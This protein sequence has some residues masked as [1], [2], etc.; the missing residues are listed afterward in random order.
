M[1]V[2]LL[3]MVLHLPQGENSDSIIYSFICTINV[4][5]GKALSDHCRGALARLLLRFFP[6]CLFNLG[7]EQGCCW[8][9]A[10]IHRGWVAMSPR[11]TGM[12][13]SGKNQSRT[14][15]VESTS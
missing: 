13:E 12:R 6:T 8:L 4:R 11:W 2:G 14:A 7:A 5:K 15:F 9:R 1:L 10:K 3:H